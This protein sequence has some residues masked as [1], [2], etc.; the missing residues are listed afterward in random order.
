MTAGDERQCAVCGAGNRAPRRFCGGC[1]APLPEACA[2]CG[3]ANDAG[4]KF[5]G[6]CGAALAAGTAAPA[7]RADAAAGE[8]ERRPI[9][10]LFADLSGYTQLSQAL[11]PEVVHAL[12]GRYFETVDAIVERF[13]G[14]VDKHI[15]DAVMAVFGA[16]V[17]HGDEALRAV[18]AAAEIQRAVPALGAELGRPLAVHIGIAGGE[19]VASGLGSSRHSAYSVVGQSVNLAARLLAL[20]ATRETV[21]DGTVEA[22]TRRFARWTAVEGAT[23]KGID[24]PVDAYRLVDIGDEGSGEGE[25]PF[26]GRQAELAQLAAALAATLGRRAGSTVLLRGEAGIGKSRLVGELARRARAEGFACHRGLV[27]D[28]G[29]AKGRDAVREI[30]AGLAGLPPGADDDARLAALDQ[31]VAAGVLAGDQRPF[32]LDLLD[33]PQPAASPALYEAMDNATRQRGR[34]DALVRLLATASARLPV[35]VIVEDVHWADPA[36]LRYLGALTRAAAKLPAVLVMTTRREG[37]PLDVAW[38]ASVEGSPLLTVD[39]GPL[40]TDDGM[41]LAGGFFAA[42]Q[43]FALRCVERAAGN[44]LFLEQL[45][46]AADEQEDRLPASLHSL[47]LARMDRLPER[48]RSALRAA[49]VIGQRFPL[50]LVRELAKLPDYDCDGLVNHYLV[51]PEGDDF[52][53]A[54]AL[55]RDGV[56]ASITRARRAELHVEAARWYGERDPSLNAEHLDRAESPAAPRAYL[57][58]AR[59]QADALHLERAVSLAERGGALARDPADM[60]ALAMLRGGLQC[61]V[62]DGRPAV[63]AYQAALAAAASPAERCRALIGIAG[64]QRLLAGIDEAFAALAEAEELAREHGITR[65]LAEL[66]YLR[67]NLH[68]ARGRTADCRREHDA[69]LACARELGDPEWEARARSG[70]GDADYA[71]GRMR[72]AREQFLRCVALCD[73]HGLTRFAIPNRLMI[74]HCSMYLGEFDAGFAAMEAGLAMARSTGNR[75]TEMFALESLGMLQN[76]RAEYRRAEPT[77]KASLDLAVTLGARR[78]QE[79]LLACLAEGWLATGR[80]AE[81]RA[82]LE[83]GLAL[84][85]E[86]GM[87]FCGPMLLGLLACVGETAAERESCRRDAEALLAAG[88]LSHNHIRYYRYGIEDALL[89]GEWARALAHADALEAY[90]RSEPLSYADLLVAR[91]RALA[92]LAAHP[93][94]SACKAEVARWR[95]EA[96][97]LNWA[98]GWPGWV[99][100]D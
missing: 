38:R 99:A 22:A 52:L 98:L 68:F 69:A 64:G 3:F 13:G 78:Y 62:G 90:T 25:Q 11:D 28:F 6:G 32:A 2:S 53:F 49:A 67:G 70:V 27:L 33:L 58:A 87:G 20:A 9:T 50:A 93:D 94:D 4:A 47:V 44:P 40:A 18:R 100:A 73:A 42:S 89:R 55:I 7:V 77:L 96:Q 63:D 35:L 88:C 92:A 37:D 65:E 21:V 75:H 82:A 1:G 85:R 79:V 10:V 84:A 15:G 26:V 30:V 72:T 12:L 34:T 31:L 5:C 16:P 48:D 36:T 91:A 29:M 41:A 54:H 74:G 17:A 59:A 39:L 24:G 66:H 61:E 23:A 45:L 56:Y 14:S 43:G 95:A 83:R 57:D 46:R 8:G 19:V 71:E 60:H 97:R 76:L 81:A 86:T 80:T 51:R